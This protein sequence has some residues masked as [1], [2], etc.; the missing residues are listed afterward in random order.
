MPE[1]RLREGPLSVAAV[2][3]RH[4]E[5]IR[6]WRNAQMDVLRQ[7]R[8]IGADEQIDYFARHIW[9]DKAKAE[10][11]NILLIIE[12]NGEPVGYGGLV[13]IA[14]AHKRAE[15]SF[16]T[17]PEIAA[18]WPHYRRCFLGFLPMAERLAFDQLGLDRLFTETY[19]TRDRHMSVLEEAG[20][21]REG[22]MRHHV[23]I[24]GRPVDSI[25]HG[26]VRDR[27]GE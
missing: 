20:F 3:P 2:E 1:A 17:K 4:I 23:R 8:P 27:D 18:D 14:W 10:P 11:A 24:D 25:L 13:H 16:L 26:R 5:A 19:A 15:I 12:E 9:P 6:Q 7:A 21:C 22:V